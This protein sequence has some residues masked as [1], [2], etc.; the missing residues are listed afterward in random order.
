MAEWTKR[1]NQ[2]CGLAQKH[3]RVRLVKNGGKGNMQYDCECPEQ[4]VSLA[5]IADGN[6]FAT[7][8]PMD[9]TD[10]YR[11]LTMVRQHRVSMVVWAVTG[12]RDYADLLAADIEDRAGYRWQELAKELIR[13]YYAPI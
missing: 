12:D 9:G 11:A 6:P 7:S 13:E 3:I 5:D 8:A 4:G 1:F 10:Y 2:F